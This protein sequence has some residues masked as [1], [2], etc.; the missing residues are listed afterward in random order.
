MIISEDYA[1]VINAILILIA[2]NYKGLDQKSRKLGVFGRKLEVNHS[3]IYCYFDEYQG[4]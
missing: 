1:L 2:F 3:P 4:N